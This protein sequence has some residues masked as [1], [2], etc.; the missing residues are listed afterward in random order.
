VHSVTE[1]PRQKELE[2]AIDGAR[3]FEAKL[4]RAMK[5]NTITIEEHAELKEEVSAVNEMSNERLIT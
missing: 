1:L 3:G 4:G 2:D 5:K